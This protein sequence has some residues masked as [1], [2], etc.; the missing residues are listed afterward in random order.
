M[1]RVGGRARWQSV[2][3][4]MYSA[5]EN[6]FS[7]FNFDTIGDISYTDFYTAL[8]FENQRNYKTLAMQAHALTRTRYFFSLNLLISHPIVYKEGLSYLSVCAI[9]SQSSPPTHVCIRNG[10]PGS[11]LCCGHC[12]QTDCSR[13]KERAPAKH[14]GL[15][16]TATL[17]ETR[18]WATVRDRQLPSAL[19]RE[20]A[21][22]ERPQSVVMD[23]NSHKVQRTS[24]AVST[25]TGHTYQQWTVANVSFVH[26]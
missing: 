20:A 13:L 5:T 10:H 7:P 21:G 17:K 4:S 22:S 8:Y 3:L 11:E 19:V 15:R 18:E 6:I 24:G 25:P 9:A 2:Y 1:E 16:G 23:V 26:L 12:K 14:W